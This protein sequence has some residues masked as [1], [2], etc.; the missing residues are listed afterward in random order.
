MG[1]WYSYDYSRVRWAPYIRLS[2]SIYSDLIEL[3]PVLRGFD[4]VAE[5]FE[6]EPEYEYCYFGITYT[7]NLFSDDESDYNY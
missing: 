7:V 2:F 6:F 1:F 4:R 5:S 3:V